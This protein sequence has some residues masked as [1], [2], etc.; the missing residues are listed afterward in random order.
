MGANAAIT[1]PSDAVIG[2][3]FSYALRLACSAASGNR[4]AYIAL[5]NRQ[6][7]LGLSF[8]PLFYLEGGGTATV[9]VSLYDPSNTTQLA[10]TSATVTGDVTPIPIAWGSDPNGYAAPLLRVDVAGSAAVNLRMVNMAAQPPP[11]SSMYVGQAVTNLAPNPCNST[12]ITNINKSQGTESIAGDAT[13]YK[14]G[15][16]ST[17]VTTTT[18][19]TSEGMLEY[20]TASAGNTYSHGTWVFCPVGYS[21][22]MEMDFFNVNTFLSQVNSGVVAGTG[23][24]KYVSVTG[25]APANTTRYAATVFKKTNGS[26]FSFWVNGYQGELSAVA[27]PFT[28]SSRAAGRIQA[29]ANLISPVQMWVI[30]RLR[31]GTANANYQN[32]FSWCNGGVTQYIELLFSSSQIYVQRQGPLAGNNAAAIGFSGSTGQHVTFG[33]AFTPTVIATMLNAGAWSGAAQ[34]DIPQQSALPST[35]DIGSRLG[36]QNPSNHA[37]YWMVVGTGDYTKINLSKPYWTADADPVLSTINA[38]SPG[39]GAT[40]VIPFTNGNII[41]LSQ[42]ASGTWSFNPEGA[43][44]ATVVPAS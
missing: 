40:A 25:T 21:F 42:A 27:T 5:A 23:T 1:A 34:T 28:P 24:W 44:T 16:G 37:L 6:P 20:I 43:A 3:S 14:Y 8:V 29:P 31:L 12:D 18:S 39:A 13:Q 15:T 2:P 38:D 22:Q 17:K 26:V 35:F 10:S 19:S 41:D 32:I 36:T 7:D 4:Y 33:G 9:T 30:A 11:D